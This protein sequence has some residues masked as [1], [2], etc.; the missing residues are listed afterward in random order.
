V[1]NAST[2]RL[3]AT[4]WGFSHN[5]VENL[6]KFLAHHDAAKLHL[7]QMRGARSSGG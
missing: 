5:S 1:R 3:E 4:E 6:C 7:F 2:Q